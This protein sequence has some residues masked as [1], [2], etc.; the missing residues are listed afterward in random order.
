MH[1]N[2]YNVENIIFGVVLEDVPRNSISSSSKRFMS[3]II[4]I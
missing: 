2:R 1:N 4:G 3:C